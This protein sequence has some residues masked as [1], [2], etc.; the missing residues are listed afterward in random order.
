MSPAPLSRLLAPPVSL[1][2][3]PESAPSI[4]V[5]K[6]ATEASLVGLE[7]P[8]Q[9]KNASAIAKVVLDARRMLLMVTFL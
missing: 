3:P 8:P 4:P 5:S 1:T 9:P 7:L 2:A 6:F